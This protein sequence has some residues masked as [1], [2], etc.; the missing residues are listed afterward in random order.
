MPIQIKKSINPFN[1]A[2]VAYHLGTPLIKQGVTL[3]HED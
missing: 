2:E 3:H 1:N